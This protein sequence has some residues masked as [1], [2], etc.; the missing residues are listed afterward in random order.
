MVMDKAADSAR[1]EEK[2]QHHRQKCG[3]VGIEDRGPRPRVALG[4]RLDG[5]CTF[6]RFLADPAED[7]DIAVHRD[8]KAQDDARDA[9]Q[10]QRGPQ[11]SEGRQRQHDVQP[12][13]CARQ[14][15]PAAVKVRPS[16]P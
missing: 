1:A 9:R 10:R 7:Q 2:Q 14:E 12:Q 11:Q 16:S 6:R 15:A 5:C 8:A 4:E 3:D 13:H